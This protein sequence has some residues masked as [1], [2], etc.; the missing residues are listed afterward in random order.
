MIAIPKPVR[1]L[2]PPVVEISG[3]LSAAMPFPKSLPATTNKDAA[4]IGLLW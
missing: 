1:P 3:E 4:W 2:L